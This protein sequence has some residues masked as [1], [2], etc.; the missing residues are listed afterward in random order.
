MH[1]ELRTNVQV[2]RSRD[3]TTLDWVQDPAVLHAVVQYARYGDPG[4][5]RYLR[6]HPFAAWMGRQERNMAA[7]ERADGDGPPEAVIEELR[8]ALDQLH[9]VEREALKRALTQSG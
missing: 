2:A 6:S 8:E 3:A 4:A 7:V 5:L 9:P 1:T